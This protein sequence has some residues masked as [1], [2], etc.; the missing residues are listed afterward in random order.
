MEQLGYVV[1]EFDDPTEKESKRLIIHNKK[2]KEKS[3][4]LFTNDDAQTKIADDDYSGIAE[5][6]K[7]L[8]E[9]INQKS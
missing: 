4:F 6:A 2:K 3:E 7:Q 8:Y 1:K 9:K 5:F